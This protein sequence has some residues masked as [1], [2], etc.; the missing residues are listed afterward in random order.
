MVSK[1]MPMW[2]TFG[3]GASEQIGAN[4]WREVFTSINGAMDRAHYH[5]WSFHLWNFNH[6]RAAA[7]ICGCCCSPIDSPSVFDLN[8]ELAPGGCIV[9]MSVLNYNFQNAKYRMSLALSVC[10]AASYQFFC[11]R[12]IGCILKL[13]STQQV[14]RSSRT[15]IRARV[16]D[17]SLV[18]FATC[19]I[20]CSDVNR[21]WLLFFGRSVGRCVQ[22]LRK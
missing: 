18:H 13:Y 3:F 15:E 8:P 1:T 19:A 20:P 6:F 11:N 16:V 17:Y 9:D 4:C 14:F 10:V 21:M 22:G 5:F 12:Y 7:P 2:R